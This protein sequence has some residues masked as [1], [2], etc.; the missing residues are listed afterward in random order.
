MNLLLILFQGVASISFFTSR[1]LLTAFGMALCGRWAAGSGMDV[2]VSSNLAIGEWT[3]SAVGSATSLPWLLTDTMLL[4]FF[5]LAA[6]EL[7]SETNEDI[8]PMYE[9]FIGF[10]QPGS[11]F[12]V[13]YSFAGW[14]ASSYIEMLRHAP[15]TTL[16]AFD[17]PSSPALLGVSGAHYSLDTLALAGI[18][19]WAAPVLSLIWA[20]VLAAATWLLGRV[21]AGVV[22]LI[23]TIDDGNSLG[24]QSLMH[25][26]ETLWVVFGAYLLI[27]L[28][29]MALLLCGISV[30]AL[31]L[32]RWYFD[33]R[34]QQSLIA[35][36]HCAGNMHPT[37][38]LCPTCRQP[39]SA[40]RRVGLFGQA[41][42]APVADPAAHRLELIARKR[43]PVCATR[44]KER[45]V[46]QACAGCGAVTFA[47]ISAVNVYMRSLQERLPKTL[48][49]CFLLGLIPVVGVVPG[50]IYYR[51]S[52]IASLKTYVPRTIGCAT[53][54]GIR[55]ATLLLISLQVIHWDRGAD[56]AG[57][58]L[59]ELH[60]ISQGDRG[61]SAPARWAAPSS[62]W[63]RRS[64]P[65]PAA[66]LRCR[67]RT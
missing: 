27:A 5:L 46:R 3:M 59:A 15:P 36:L 23:N 1:P 57:D 65:G 7:F 22:D 66:R 63:R 20:G 31:F 33:R 2:D 52:L 10:V 14:Q 28:P 21:R 25:W 56:A 39:N 19:S 44:L 38:L 51:L 16:L 54:W 30:A 61:A 42:D 34:E 41:K 58:V 45:A 47:D 37:A 11:A 55:L 62:R 40:A 18:L 43:C 17:L 49:I 67:R 50:V 9:D 4:I 32:I 60:R 64:A 35:C 6:F 29:L 24:L 13:N 12:A 8:R 53:R 26:T 48:A